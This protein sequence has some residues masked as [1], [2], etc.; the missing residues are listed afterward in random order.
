MAGAEALASAILVVEEPQASAR[1]YVS[2]S[3][4]DS[5]PGTLAQP[6]KTFNRAYQAA[7]PGD[8]VE[9]AGGVYNE[10]TILAKASAQA[11]NVLFRPAAGAS[12][13]IGMS[14]TNDDLEVY[15]SY[16]TFKD[17]SIFDNWYAR[18][19]TRGLVF[20]NVRA[21]KFYCRSVEDLKIL[22]GSYISPQATGVPTISAMDS[23]SPPSRDV[24]ME[25]VLIERI[26]RPEGDTTSHREGLHVMGVDGLTMRR[27][28]IREVLGNT[29]A[30]SF[31]IHHSSVVRR[32]LLEDCLIE[33]TYGGGA[34][35]QPTG[36]GPSVNISDRAPG[37][38]ITF[39]RLR[40]RDGSPVVPQ[41]H[42]EYPG[43]IRFED[44]VF[45]SHP[46][47]GGNA[48]EYF[49]DYILEA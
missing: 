37:Y 19:G 36:S 12:V 26:W 6:F 45:A 42:P 14:A 8:V 7:A 44:C 34:Y 49:W 32:V 46:N 15:G 17:L 35:P 27:C 22:G 13:Q 21:Q 39:R 33:G 40:S 9:V 1:W 25:D 41:G 4:S 20:D 10:Q 18:P 2:P 43:A 48:S 47:M 30:L 29:A 16:V 5:A 3:G 23:S 31:N 38:E 11:P 28:T 24:L